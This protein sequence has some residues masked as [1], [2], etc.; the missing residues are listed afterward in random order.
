MRWGLTPNSSVFLKPVYF[1]SCW[2]QGYQHLVQNATDC[3]H[4]APLRGRSTDLALTTIQWG[5]LGD[6]KGGRLLMGAAE[7]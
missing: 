4:F 6:Q 5:G 2:R 1:R 3:R 7:W